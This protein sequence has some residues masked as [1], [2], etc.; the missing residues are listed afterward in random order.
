MDRHCDFELKIIQR[1]EKMREKNG[2]FDLTK[3]KNGIS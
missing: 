3:Q 1:E 2:D